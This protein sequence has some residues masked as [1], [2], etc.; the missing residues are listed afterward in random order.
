MGHQHNNLSTLPLRVRKR[1][2]VEVR[3]D[4][5]KIESAIRR[6]GQ[7]SG[8]F[9]TPE[10]SLLTAQVVKVLAHRYGADRLPDI[11]G[12]QDVVEQTLISANHF[13]TARSYIVY[14]EQHKK[15]RDERRTLVDVG[16][17]IN[18][19]LDRSDWRVAANANQGY[20][21]GGLILN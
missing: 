12:I 17:S 1:D 6:A 4:A 5:A 21:L 20:S 15:L 9:G 11:E 16:G 13:E 18:E 8:E 19:Y 10:A 7:A 3:F 2:G 14:R